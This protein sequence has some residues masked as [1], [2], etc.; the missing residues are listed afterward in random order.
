M[1]VNDSPIEPLVPIS[2]GG[3]EYTLCFPIPALWAFHD[4]TGIDLVNGGKPKESDSKRAY[5]E[6]TIALCWAGLITKHPGITREEVGSMI[7]IGN[8]QYVERLVAKAIEAT[9]SKEQT[10][11]KEEATQ[12]APLVV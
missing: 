2:L 10:G 11:A 6:H 1:I 8:F 9:M 5:F 12:G 4:V 7:F 3:K